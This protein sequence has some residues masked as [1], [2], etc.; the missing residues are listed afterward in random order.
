MLIVGELIFRCI[1]QQISI[2][3]FDLPDFIQLN[4]HKGLQFNEY[5]LYCFESYCSY[6]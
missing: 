6:L 3:V 5:L 4:F 1:L 2:T